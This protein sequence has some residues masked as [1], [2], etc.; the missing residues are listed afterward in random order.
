MNGRE[1]ET[2]L[3]K[4]A[5]ELGCSLLSTYGENGD[6]HLEDEVIRRIQ[7]S[8]RGMREQRL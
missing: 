1:R 3:R 6:K 4:L 2:E 5:T 8:V 7:E